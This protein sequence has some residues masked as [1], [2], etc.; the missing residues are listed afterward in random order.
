M[1]RKKAGQTKAKAKR[2]DTEKAWKQDVWEKPSKQARIALASQA[3]AA[4]Q[5]VLPGPPPEL[6]AHTPS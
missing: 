5:P 4:A 3:A 1:V 6:T 2:K